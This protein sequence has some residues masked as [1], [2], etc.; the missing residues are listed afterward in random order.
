VSV[1]ILAEKFRWFELS[2]DVSPLTGLLAVSRSAFEN[3]TGSV[4]SRLSGVNTSRIGTMGMLV[5]DRR[6]QPH[7]AQMP[8]TSPR[9]KF[10][11]ACVVQLCNFIGEGEM[12]W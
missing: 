11:A 2:L 9:L 6:L 7:D 1:E 8:L 4:A 12:K 3:G 5:G 10:I